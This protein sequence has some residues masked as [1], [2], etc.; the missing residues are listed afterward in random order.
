[1]HLWR[2]RGGTQVLLTSQHGAANTATR[3]SLDGRTLATVDGL[4]DV[5]LLRDLTTGEH[6]AMFEGHVHYN[7]FLP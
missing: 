1:M 7:G 3:F 4:N 6:L 5:I 2:A